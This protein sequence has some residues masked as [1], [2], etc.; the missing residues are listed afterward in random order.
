MKALRYDRNNGKALALQGGKVFSRNAAFSPCFPFHYGGRW[1]CLPT[2]WVAGSW[3][4]VSPE[5]GSSNPESS[6]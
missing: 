2:N 6:A 3:A 1:T 5:A 4:M